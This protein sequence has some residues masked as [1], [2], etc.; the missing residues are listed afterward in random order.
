[1]TL[2]DRDSTKIASAMN[3]KLNHMQMGLSEMHL[4]SDAKSRLNDIIQTSSRLVK[5]NDA[6]NDIWSL[7]E[8][9]SYAIGF[10]SLI[11]Q[12]VV[13][14]KVGVTSGEEFHSLVDRA[15]IFCGIA[16][17]ACKNGR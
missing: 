7:K 5:E 10:L 1:M 4:A 13:A 2:T 9:G 15:D 3:A 12:I 6:R 8:I 16:E 14:R 11:D 17:R